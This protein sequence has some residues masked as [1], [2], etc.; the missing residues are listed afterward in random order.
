MLGPRALRPYGS[1]TVAIAG[2][3]RA[4]TLYV[5]VEGR[6][7]NGEQFTKGREVQVPAATSRLIE[8]EVSIHRLYD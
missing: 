5:A 3:S 8:L 2:G 4:Y 1:Y 6:R 7:A